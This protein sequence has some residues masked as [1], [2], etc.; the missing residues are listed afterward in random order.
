MGFGTGLNALLTSQFALENK[1]E[2]NYTGIEAFPVEKELLE[3]LNYT[4]ELG[5]KSQVDFDLIHRL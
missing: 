3:S 5:E 4:K 2:V 1:V